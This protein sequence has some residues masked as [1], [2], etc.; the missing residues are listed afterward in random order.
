MTR[1]HV[2]LALS[3]GFILG[4]V[5]QDQAQSDADFAL[6]PPPDTAAMVASPEELQPPAAEVATTPPPVAGTVRPRQP[7]PSTAQPAPRPAADVAPAPAPAP[8]P[9]PAPA[10]LV[11]PVGT[12]MVM[13]STV[14]ITSRRNKAGETFTAR[15]TEPVR[16]ASDRDVVPAGSVV[17]F[18]IVE[19]K[20]AENRDA[21]GTLIIRPVSV[22]IGGQRYDVR[23]DVVDLQYS[24]EGR[25]VTAGDAGK[26]AVGAAAG[27][28]AGRIIGRRT[29]GAVVGGAVGAAAGTMIAIQTADRDVV[30][31]EGSRIVLRLTEALGR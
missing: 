9:A 19:I 12:E 5:K 16:D 21:P 29:S 14:E 11:A 17:T 3:A 25:G 4:C 15:V 28:I 6:I 27:A 26:V 20:E 31:P 30:V 1:T 24:L 10:P 13:A 8:P 23:G 18:S 2:F 22:E 7:A